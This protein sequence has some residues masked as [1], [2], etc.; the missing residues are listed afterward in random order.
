MSY[1]FGSH[2]EDV[3]SSSAGDCGEGD[4]STKDGF[5][6]WTDAFEAGD[7]SVEAKSYGAGG[8]DGEEV[9]LSDLWDGE[10]SGF[11]GVGV[12]DGDVERLVCDLPE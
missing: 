9:G 5:G 3:Q 8:R 12:I 6:G 4:Q 11:V 10:R 2:E 7:E 1:L